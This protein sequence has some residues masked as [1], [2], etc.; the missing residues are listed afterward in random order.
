MKT[1][2]C[3]KK[4]QT[5]L[6]GSVRHFCIFQ[7]QPHLRVCKQGGVEVVRKFCS[8]FIHC[9]NRY[10]LL[11]RSTFFLLA[12]CSVRFLHCLLISSCLYYRSGVFKLRG[13]P[14]NSFRGGFSKLCLRGGPQSQTL[15]NPVIE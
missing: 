13:G 14:P 9:H 10:R 15:K 5:R 1:K 11:N 6:K 3:W 4:K 2:C 7:K 8:C 12:N